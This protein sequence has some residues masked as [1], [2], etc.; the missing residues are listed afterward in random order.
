MRK[1]FKRLLGS[2]P[3][4][5]IPPHMVWKDQEF[6]QRAKKNHAVSGIPDIR[7]YFL[8][9][10]IRSLEQIPGAV[11]EC[12]VR[13]G[14][15]AL[16]MMEASE[17]R[18]DFYLFDSFE[19]LSDPIPLKDSIR[20][21]FRKGDKHRRFAVEYEAVRS[22]LEKNPRFHVLKGWIPE[23]FGEVSNKTFC[24]AHIDVDLYQ[25]TLDSLNYFYPRLS[26]HGIIVC[27]DYGSGHYPGARLAFDEFFA[28]KPEVPI[29]LP[30]GQCFIIK[31]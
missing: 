20:S 11:G 2:E 14:K 9:S 15:S 12:G 27:D 17:N 21:A 13:E 23:R 30:Q 19:G 22:R 1:L 29:E 7:C 4:H 25:P 3:K 8:Q 10:C 16:F 31:R 18:R 24:L 6:F 28:D 26:Q 5:R